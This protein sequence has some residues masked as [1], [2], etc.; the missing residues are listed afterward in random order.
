MAE[1]WLAEQLEEGE[2]RWPAEH[3]LAWQRLRAGVAGGCSGPG[4]LKAGSGP[5]WLE[6]RREGGWRL[7]AR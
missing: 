5:G 2:S 6:A 1:S 7:E 3:L 4:R